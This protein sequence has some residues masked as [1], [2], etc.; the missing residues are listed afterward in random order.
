[1][2]AEALVLAPAGM[3]ATRSG[4]APADPD[5]AVGHD[6]GRPRPLHPGFAAITGSGDLWTTTGDL[7]RL[8]QALRAGAVV[9]TRSAALLWTQHAALPAGEPRQ[10]GPMTLT[11]YGY[12][13]FLGQVRGH[14]ARVNPGD[15]PGYETLL[16]HLPDQDARPRGALQRGAAEP[17]RS[18]N[19]TPTSLTSPQ[20]VTHAPSTPTDLASPTLLALVMQQISRTTVGHCVRPARGP[21]AATPCLTSP[22]HTGAALS[23]VVVLFGG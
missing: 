13:T 12:G 19:R 23:V 20:N 17:E 16:A 2:T 6:H 1:M 21:L 9:S 3:T 15:M 4:A 8:N 11:G 10:P 22:T 5:L 18:A 7:V 14:R